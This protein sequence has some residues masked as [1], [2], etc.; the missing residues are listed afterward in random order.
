MP[1]FRRLNSRTVHS[2]AVWDLVEVEI[3][4]PHG[5]TFVRTFVDSP[6]AVAV[7][8]LDSRGRVTLVRQYR[9]PYDDHM[10]E[11]PAGMRDVPGE[12]P[13]LTAEREL[14]EEVGLAAASLTPIGRCSSAPGITNSD[15]ELFLATGLS[16]VPIDPHGPEEMTM[17]SETIPLGKALSL[18]G[19]G[20]I[21]DSKTVIGLLLV[22]RMLS[23][24]SVSP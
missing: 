7:V 16:S 17:S 21:V 15:V 24:G 6:G 1:G 10:L 18:V 4:A 9:A 2:W 12:D 8:P 19:T 13:R 5:E 20:V 14:A 23:S 22:D 3:E 11:I